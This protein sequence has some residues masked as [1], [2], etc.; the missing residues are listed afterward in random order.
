MK[1]ILMVP[2]IVLSRVLLLTPYVIDHFED[3][4]FQLINKLIEINILI[5]TQ[6]CNHGQLQR[7]VDGHESYCWTTDSVARQASKVSMP[8]WLVSNS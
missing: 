5:K 3:L 7:V 8:G 4:E 2:W 6:Y 1:A